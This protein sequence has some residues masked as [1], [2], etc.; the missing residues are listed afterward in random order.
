LS[1]TWHRRRRCGHGLLALALLAV[2]GGAHA[3][4]VEF[5]ASRS[6][7]SG[8]Y[9]T[10]D[11]QAL[12]LGWHGQSDRLVQL[13]FEHKQA[14][15]ETASLAIGSIAQD[16]TAEDRAGFAVAASDAKTIV[17][18]SR[19]DAF[20]SRKM[21]PARNLVATLAGY[22]THVADGHQDLGLVGSAAW[23]LPDSQ[24]A[25]AGLRW[26]RSNPGSNRAW[27]GFVGATWGAVG[28]DT[29]ALHLEGGHEAYQSLGAN[30]AV[31]DFRSDEVTLG[32]RHWLRPDA[33]F[34][35]DAGL[36]HNPTY[37]K[38]TLGATGFIRF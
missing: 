9:A 24:V 19:V 12:R 33:G 15:G 30:A 10:Q 4:D 27:R 13:S 14:F 17:A 2:S 29:L 7:L 5:G 11:T 37:S 22:A 38:R 23:Y 21:L 18:Q 6:S 25:E 3:V 35:L 31:A 32:W 36:Y 34:A 20:Y 26:A 8:G 16:L 28:R 1:V